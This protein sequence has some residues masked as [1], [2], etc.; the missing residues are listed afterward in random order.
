MNR[1]AEGSVVADSGKTP[2]LDAILAQHTAAFVEAREAA[3]AEEEMATEEAVSAEGDETAQGDT[4]APTEPA[5]E[6]EAEASAEEAEETAAPGESEA[7]AVAEAKGIAK[8]LQILDKTDPAA[9][10]AV[11][12]LQTALGKSREEIRAQE[13]ERAEFEV[14]KK[15]LDQILADYRTSVAAETA[16][17]PTAEQQGQADELE[18]AMEEEGLSPEQKAMYRKLMGVAIDGAIKSKRLVSADS[19]QQQE[20]TKAQG[21]YVSGAHKAAATAFG[22]AFGKV[23]DDGALVMDRALGAPQGPHAKVLADTRN[24]LS[25]SEQGMT[26]ADVFKVARY[27]EAVKEAYQRGLAE[28]A[29]KAAEAARNT[30]RRK[31]GTV[32]ASTPAANGTSRF[33]PQKGESRDAMLDRIIAFKMKHAV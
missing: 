3:E 17:E 2:S 15:E 5:P 32:S 8:S 24:R 1:V 27:D 9:A 33:T 22:E 25:S 26:W 29:T 20:R 7:P 4:E 11:R 31:A 6:T 16:P 23:S 12:E 18:K 28:T 30:A 14:S 13:R 10:K 19:I 21:S